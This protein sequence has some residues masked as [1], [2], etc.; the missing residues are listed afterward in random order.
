VKGKKRYYALDDIGIVGV[1]KGTSKIQLRRDME[2]TSQ[3]F[4]T[5][6]GGAKV[7]AVKASKAGRFATKTS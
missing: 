5:H 3:Y 1:Q 2:R 7:M 6:K 4:K